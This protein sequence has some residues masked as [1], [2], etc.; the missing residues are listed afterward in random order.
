LPPEPGLPPVVAVGCA[1]ACVLAGAVL[2][3]VGVF[4]GVAVLVG[5]GG[6]GV[7]VGGW[8]GGPPRSP[9]PC[10]LQLLMPPW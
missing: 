3:G 4:V 1:G 2:V 10:G 8:Y 7:A 9:G 6:A 5:V